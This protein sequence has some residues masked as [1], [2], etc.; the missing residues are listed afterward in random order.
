M[1]KLNEC[2]NQILQNDTP[3]LRCEFCKHQH[4]V[5]VAVDKAREDWI[6]KMTNEVEAAMTKGSV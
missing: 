2:W 5:K 1:L 3:S 4:A 6:A